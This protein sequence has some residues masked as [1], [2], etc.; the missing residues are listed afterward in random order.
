MSLYKVTV[1]FQGAATLEIEADSPEAVRLE[2]K[3]LTIA[4]LARAERTDIRALQVPRRRD[5]VSQDP[6]LRLASAIV[7]IDYDELRCDCD[8]RGA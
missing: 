7:S 4:D 8:W 2:A 5:C 3:E 1:T 6:P